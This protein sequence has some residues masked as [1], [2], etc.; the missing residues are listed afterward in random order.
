[1]N[2]KGQ[3]HHSL[4]LVQG[5]SDSTFPNFFSLETAKLIDAKFHVDGGMKVNTNVLCHMTKLDAM[6]IHGKKL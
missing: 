2:I 6:P 5:H 3:G 1:M 4:T